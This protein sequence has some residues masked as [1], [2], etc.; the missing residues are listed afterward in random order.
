M[1]GES[2]IVLYMRV[3]V[4]FNSGC[5]SSINFERLGKRHTCS[6]NIMS[7]VSELG[8]IPAP[9]W[10]CMLAVWLGELITCTATA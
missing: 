5:C 9:F 3:D 2:E 1:K 7:Y 6:G 4:Y 10:V 8:E